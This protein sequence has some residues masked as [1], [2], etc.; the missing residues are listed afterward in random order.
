M[1]RPGNH[2]VSVIGDCVNRRID[3]R[4]FTVV[5]FRHCRLTTPRWSRSPSAAA[6]SPCRPPAARFLRVHPLR[7]DDALQFAAAFAAAER[8]TAS[9]EIVALDDRLADAAGKEGFVVFDAA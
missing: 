5:P 4:S 1:G 8:R 3:G 6:T 9:L 7:A 2:V